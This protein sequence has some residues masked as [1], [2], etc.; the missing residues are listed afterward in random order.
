MAEV[1]KTGTDSS[2]NSC[3]TLVVW[4]LSLMCTALLQLKSTKLCLVFSKHGKWWRWTYH[5]KLHTWLGLPSSPT[6]PNA[7]WKSEKEGKWG[8]KAQ[9]RGW[10][11][12]GR[13]APLPGY[14]TQGEVFHKLCYYSHHFSHHFREVAC[15]KMKL[16]WMVS[17]HTNWRE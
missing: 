9:S 1:L 16:F 7:R 6:A 17:T 3:L 11:G 14:V 15:H 2:L 10:L 12:C 13:D 5:L 8:W 4:H